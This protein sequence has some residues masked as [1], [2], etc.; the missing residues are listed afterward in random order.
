MTS[1]KA[2]DQDCLEGLLLEKLGLSNC[3]CVVLLCSHF[4]EFFYL[5]L[6][7]IKSLCQLSHYPAIAF[8]SSKI[9]VDLPVLSYL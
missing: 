2:H 6:R 9:G 3:L 7:E 4:T 5:F 8:D 1:E